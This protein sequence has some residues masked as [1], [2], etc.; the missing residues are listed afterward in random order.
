M[1]THPTH[2]AFLSTKEPRMVSVGATGHS[3]SVDEFGALWAWGRNNSRGGGGNF[4]TMD[5]SGQVGVGEGPETDPHRI[6]L[7]PGSRA[8]S[9]E[10]VASGRYFSLAL[11]SAGEVWSWGMNDRG[12]LGRA[13]SDKKAGEGPCYSGEECRDP[14][15]RP[16]ESDLRFRWVSAARY[17]SVAVS[18][19]GRL[20]VWG[21]DQCGNPDAERLKSE[22][23]SPADLASA[24]PRQLTVREGGKEISFRSVDAGYF[25]WLALDASG[26][27]WSCNNG[28]DGYTGFLSEKLNGW[29][30]FN[31]ERE[32]GR[33]GPGLVP[34]RVEGIQDAVQVAAGRCGSGAVLRDGTPLIWGCRM[35]AGKDAAH[36]G[37]NAPKQVPGLGPGTPGGKVAI[38][39][40]AEACA[41]AGG[42]DGR[43]WA[44][45]R[46]GA[47]KEGVESP[48]DSPQ[49]VPLQLHGELPDGGRVVALAGGHQHFLAVVEVK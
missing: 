1:E 6:E 41:V 8:P 10:R 19:D 45:G 38:L 40:V 35:V 31:A 16:I 17:S 27:V 37:A 36:P 44:W 49:D 18:Q 29:R 25:H 30:E 14:W 23:K 15:P 7:L 13:G 3:V 34:G 47:L 26:G 46:V 32:L 9:F 21:I 11:S 43:L 24:K 28:D 2:D 12:Q 22:G 20:W 5:D 48:N 4:Y 42:E 39:A 33:Q